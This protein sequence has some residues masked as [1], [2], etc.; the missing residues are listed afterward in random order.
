MTAE[1]VVTQKTT[2]DVAQRFK[3]L[4]KNDKTYVLGIMNGILLKS[5]KK[6]VK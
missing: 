4:S 2:T 6:V 5:E 1:D 3:Q